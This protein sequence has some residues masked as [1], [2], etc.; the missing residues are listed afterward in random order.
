MKNKGFT[1]VELIIVIILLGIFLAMIFP[2][3]S[4]VTNTA[5]SNVSGSNISTLQRQIDLWYLHHDNTYPI[6]PPG[7]I[8]ESFCSD[9]KYFWNNCPA[10]SIGAWCL[11]QYGIV[12]DVADITTDCNSDLDCGTYSVA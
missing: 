4:N 7:E 1:I 5:S 12:C 3:I 10:P 2:R 9:A 8:P 6:T 11:D